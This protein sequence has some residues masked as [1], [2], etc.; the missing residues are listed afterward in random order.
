MGPLRAKPDVT[1]AGLR[2]PSPSFGFRDYE[3]ETLPDVEL[4]DSFRDVIKKLAIYIAEAVVLPC[5]FEQLRTT[6]AGDQLRTLVAHL[7]STCENPCI[8]N[9]LLTLKWHYGAAGGDRSLNEARANACEIVA[10]RFLTHLSER[11]AV[12]FCLYEIPSTKKAPGGVAAGCQDEENSSGRCHQRQSGSNRNIDENAPLLRQIWSSATSDSDRAST[13]RRPKNGSRRYQLLRSIS[14]LTMSLHRSADHGPN[15]PDGSC[16]DGDDENNSDED[17]DGDDPTAPFVNLNALEIAAV[18]DAKRFLSQNVVQ[19]II[20]GIWNGNII[21]WDRLE[22]DAVKKPR[23]YNPHTADPFSRLRV[24]KYV[25]TFEVLYFLLFLVIFY[26]TLLTEDPFHVSAAEVVFYIFLAAFAYDELSEWIDAGSLF[27]VYDLWN[28]FDLIMMCI[29]FVFVV[30]RI[31]GLSKNDAYLID[32]SFNILSLEALFMVPRIGS[33]LSLSPY[34]GTLIPC[35]K[36]MAKDFAKFMVLVVIV[37]LG[38]LTTFSLLGRTIFTLPHMTMVLTKIF[39]G[40]SSVGFDIMDKI[41]P[42]F[43]P[44]LM[45]LFVMLSS[46]LL[47]GSLMGMLSNSFSR[48]MGHAREEYLYVYSIF[49][50]EASTSNRLT[51]FYPPSNLLALV[52]FRPLRLFLPSDHKFRAARIALLKATHLP[53]VAAI[54]IYELARGRIQYAG[55]EYSAV[56]EKTSHGRLQG[57]NS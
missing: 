3:A 42:V 48:V 32:L 5:T 51:H 37:Y 16:S 13:N 39:F 28:V 47:M 4:N 53:I 27:Y 12:D 14:R 22:V 23:F 44:P 18:A 57:Q 45:L 54:Q 29:G 43:G 21:F 33:I 7:R 55:D 8:V 52:I 25:K 35:F 50:L 19:K 6:S 11:E 10:W 41:D 9:A 2:S 17:D 1:G 30:S 49:V 15:G 36:E 34:W 46:F 26:L 56:Q 40:S 24:P 38:F 20:T 31:V